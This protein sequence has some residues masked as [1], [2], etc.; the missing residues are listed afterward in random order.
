MPHRLEQEVRRSTPPPEGEGVPGRIVAFNAAGGAEA[1]HCANLD[2]QFNVFIAE[3]LWKPTSDLNSE[4]GSPEEMETYLAGIDDCATLRQLSLSL[5]RMCFE[6][7]SHPAMKGRQSIAVHRQSVRRSESLGIKSPRTDSKPSSISVLPLS[8]STGIKSP[9]NCKAPSI[10]ALLPSMSTASVEGFLVPHVQGTMEVADDGGYSGLGE[11]EITMELGRGSFGVV[12]L[13]FN[14]DNEPFAIKSIPRSH[15]RDGL[16][17][18]YS[19]SATL[20]TLNASSEDPALV[21]REIALMKRLRHRNLVRLHAVIDDI[22]D[23]QCH[24]VMQFIENGPIA[25][26]KR[27]GT[28]NPVPVDDAL[29]YMIQV[30]AGLDY[31]HRHNIV[32]RDIKPEN[33]LIGHD[34]MAYVADFGVSAVV[35]EDAM[36]LKKAQGTMSFFSPELIDDATAAATYG[37]ESDAWAFGVTLYAI[38]FGKLPFQGWNAPSIIRAI[39]NAEVTFPE[40]STVPKSVEDLVRA[41]LDK[42]PST[43]LTLKTFRAKAKVLLRVMSHKDY[44]AYAD[45]GAKEEGTSSDSE[46]SDNSVDDL[47]DRRRPVHHGHV[48]VQ[49]RRAT[50]FASP[51]PSPRPPHVPRPPMQGYRLFSVVP[52]DEPLEAKVASDDGD[53]PSP[54]VERLRAKATA[55]DQS[56]SKFS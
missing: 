48:D 52:L 15:V 44:P 53:T 26:I 16:G 45:D 46:H 35:D 4:L 12:H 41:L 3:H 9:T 2:R 13:A 14:Q 1:A 33:I 50:V 49:R 40:G 43:R 17:G 19:G 56:C 18:S 27:D 7:R 8:T 5:Y 32:H 37:K 10:P 20:S 11:Y 22:V 29:H 6:H 42:N 28:C 23:G 39:C 36:P 24:L 31:L 54:F 21:D 30:S 38:L 25:T 47:S 34:K 51:P 55:V